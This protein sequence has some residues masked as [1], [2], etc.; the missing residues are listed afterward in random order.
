L[1]RWSPFAIL[2]FPHSFFD[3]LSSQGKPMDLRDCT[4]SFPAS[5]PS[6]TRRLARRKGARQVGR[7][8]DQRRVHGLWVLGTTARFDLLTD[9]QLRRIAEIVAQVAAGDSPWSHVS[10]MGTERTKARATL[11]DDLPYDYYAA[12]PP[13]YQP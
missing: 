12:L 13:W 11:L 10:D 4:A 9:A 5:N 8:P 6:E 2:D 1:R 3:R 7:I